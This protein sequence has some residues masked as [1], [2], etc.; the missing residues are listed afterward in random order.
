M[1]PPTDRCLLAF[2]PCYNES[3]TVAATI[4]ATLDAGVQWVIVAAPDDEAR[5]QVRISGP[6]LADGGLWT[7]QGLSG[8]VVELQGQVYWMKSSQLLRP[9][10]DAQGRVTGLLVD[11]SRVRNLPFRR[12]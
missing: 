6:V 5:M 4:R 9:Q 8:D 3:A 12:C 11:T 7:L 1:P 10:R 2:M